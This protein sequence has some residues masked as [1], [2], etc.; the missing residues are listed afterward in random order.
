[1]AICA[2]DAHAHGRRQLGAL[3][4]GRVEL[5]VEGQAD[6]TLDHVLFVADGRDQHRNPAAGDR[7]DERMAGEKASFGQR[8]LE[9]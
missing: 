8:P 3:D 6:E 9:P 5:E 7:P 1:M 4:A 2:D